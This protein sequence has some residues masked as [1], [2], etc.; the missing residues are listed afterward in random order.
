MTCELWEFIHSKQH[1]KQIRGE[2]KVNIFFAEQQGGEQAVHGWD[3]VL[4]GWMVGSGPTQ[5]DG[6]IGSWLDGRWD[7]ILAGWLVGLVPGWWDQILA[8]WMVGL[9]P[10]WKEGGIRSWLAG[11]WD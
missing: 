7:Q 4:D 9:D 5:L 2:T 6:V 1:R 3:Q 8:S 10:G 11:Q